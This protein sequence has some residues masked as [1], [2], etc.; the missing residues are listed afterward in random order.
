MLH[1]DLANTLTFLPSD[2]MTSR[3]AALENAR[4]MLESGKGP[5]GEFTGWVRLPHDYDHEEYDRIQAAARRIRSAVSASRQASST[6]RPPGGGA[7]SRGSW[8]PSRRR[9]FR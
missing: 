1:V 9:W 4:A 5:G 8:R 3:T 7:A 6:A 2:W